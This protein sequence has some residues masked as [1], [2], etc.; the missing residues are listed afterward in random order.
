MWSPR[1]AKTAAHLFAMAAMRLSIQTLGNTV[2]LWK[3][4]IYKS[5]DS[6]RRLGHAAM[7]RRGV[8]PKHARLDS[9][10]GEHA[11]TRTTYALYCFRLQA[12]SPG[13]LYAVSHYH[14]EN[15]G[16]LY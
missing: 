16:N 3:F 4:A 13:R 14:L 7:R 9:R 12:C 15:K 6:S 2:P 10:S 8:C 11:G 1:T 5:P